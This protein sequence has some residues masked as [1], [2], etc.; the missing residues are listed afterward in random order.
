MRVKNFLLDSKTRL[1]FFSVSIMLLTLTTVT[2]PNPEC[3]YIWKPR[4]ESPSRCPECFT[5]LT[6]RKR[7]K[8]LS[9]ISSLLPSDS[10]VDKTKNGEEPLA[11]SKYVQNE[12]SSDDVLLVQPE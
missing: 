11:P 7:R 1:W 3:L 2:C 4:V 6:V 12:S 10:D 5:R 9:K 8:T